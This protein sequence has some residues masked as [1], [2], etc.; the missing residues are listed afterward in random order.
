MDLERLTPKR[1]LSK[2]AVSM[3]KVKGLIEN[4]IGIFVLM[5]LY[6]VHVYFSWKAWIGWIIL[7]LIGIT[8]LGAIWDIF[9]RPNLLYK[10]WRYDLDREYL[11]LKYGAIRERHEIIPMTKIQSVITKEGPLL[12]KYSLCTIEIETMGSSHG[13]PALPKDVA[14]QVRNEIAYYA[15]VKEEDE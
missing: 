11:Q 7:V 14:L 13:I 8:F 9:I 2:D 6:A 10:H 4:G 12:R 5:V 1:R 3:W 15:K